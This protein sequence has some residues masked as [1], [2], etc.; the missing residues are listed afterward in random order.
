M[1]EPIEV[2]TRVLYSGTVERCVG[3]EFTIKDHMTWDAY[4]A[5]EIVAHQSSDGYRYTV[6]PVVPGTVSSNPDLDYL[7][8]VRRQSL[9]I[10][11]VAGGGGGGEF[12][13]EKPS[14]LLAQDLSELLAPHELTD[15]YLL[16]YS[17][18]YMHITRDAE[19]NM[20]FE[21]LDPTCVIVK[22]KE[23]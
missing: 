17:N 21:I 22:T 7:S 20:E 10:V 4:T 1:N 8:F 13:A 18:A 15:W 19:G 5:P 3:A 14:A 16:I 23:T 9:E 6:V 2:G 11:A 12:A